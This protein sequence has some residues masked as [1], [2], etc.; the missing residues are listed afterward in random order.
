MEGVIGGYRGRDVVPVFQGEGDGEGHAG[1][2]ARD[3]DLQSR[4]IGRCFEVAGK[5]WEPG[6]LFV[7][8]KR[9]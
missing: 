8:K 4:G 6:G 3:V 9:R 7:N 2:G 5:S 1:G